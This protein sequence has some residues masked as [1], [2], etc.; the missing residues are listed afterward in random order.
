MKKLS[1]IDNLCQELEGFGALSVAA[2][3]A[4]LQLSPKNELAWVRLE[5]LALCGASLS[6]EN[7]STPSP[8]RLRAW[9]ASEY[10]SGMAHLEDP[11]PGPMVETVAFHGG[12]YRVFHGPQTDTLF[13]LRTV[14]SATL[15][16]EGPAEAAYH[17]WASRL[18]TAMLAVSDEIAQR[19]GLGNTVPFET[20]GTSFTIPT[21]SQLSC[22]RSAVEFSKSELTALLSRHGV[23]LADLAPL[24]APVGTANPEAGTEDH[25]L[26]ETPIIY[27][28][29]QF[30]VCI[31]RG[32]PTSL[33]RHLLCR[34]VD[35]GSQHEVATRILETAS[36][37]LFEGLHRMGIA[38]T[39]IELPTPLDVGVGR[40]WIFRFD[41]DKLMYGCLRVM[42]TRSC[43][44]AT[45]T[46]PCDTESRKWGSTGSLATL[47]SLSQIPSQR[48]FGF[49]NAKI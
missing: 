49:S 24:I 30:V 39:T 12:G 15:A 20:S 21:G 18:T 26:L 43:E 31:P 23:S 46:S 44:T 22:L 38:P 35:Q 17:E 37:T 13:N 28:G 9:L 11:Q 8:H 5:Q 6:S 1:P 32:L 27:Q 7:R 40:E 48:L 33:I 4:A 45:R 10:I 34:A 36:K 42:R 29:E 16:H 19:A 47:T 41:L 3:A 2:S 14:L 25:Q